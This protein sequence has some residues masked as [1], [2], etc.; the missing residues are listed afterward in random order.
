MYVCV[1]VG[2][3]YS[4]SLEACTC[5]R[6]TAVHVLMCHTQ[7]DFGVLREQN[8]LSLDVSVDHMMGVKMGKTLED[9]YT[10]THINRYS[11]QSDDRH[12]H[13]HETLL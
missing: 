1:T 6:E 3:L 7:F 2:R 12:R 5:A 4:C 9:I 8:I 11:T 13:K 10:H